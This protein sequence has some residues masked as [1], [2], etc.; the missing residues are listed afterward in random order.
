MVP[1]VRLGLCTVIPFFELTPTWNPYRREIEEALA[2]VLES[3]QV[4]MGEEVSSFEEEF[5]SY[6]GAQTSVAVGSGTAALT[7]ALRALG[8]GPNDEVL[9]V[10]N[11]GVPTVAAIR[12]TGALPVLV[13]VEPGT[14]LMSHSLLEAA[15]SER[16]RAVLPVHLY[17][18]PVDLDAFLAVASRH[19]L[20][21][22]EDC[23]HAHGAFYRG[24][25]V[26]TFGDVGCFSFYPTKN[27]GA[28]GDGGICVTDDYAIAGRLR[29]QRMYGYRE[30]SYSH[31]EGLNSRLDSIQAAILRVKLAHLDHAVSERRE[32]AAYYREGLSDRGY[33]MQSPTEGGKHA[34]H[35]YVIRTPVRAETIIELRHAGVGVG[36]HYPLA[37]HEM[38]AYTFLDRPGELSVSEQVC[39]RVI[40]LPLYPGMPA[41]VQKRVLDAL[42]ALDE[43]AWEVAG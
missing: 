38:A 15:I 39:K 25:H 1:G 8:I 31:E 12:A 4:I 13:D 14:M 30:D 36:I 29:G 37:I 33:R 32:L 24:Q 18:Q 2:R 42:P 9:T 11:A 26:G 7:L 10:S 41:G 21:L 3:G 5:A 17:G 6:V 27:L 16:T 34:Y 35:L 28:F 43:F 40:S 22:V 19:S 20:R 23:S